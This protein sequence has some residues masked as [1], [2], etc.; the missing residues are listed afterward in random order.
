MLSQLL[1]QRTGNTEGFRPGLTFPLFH[2]S[3]HSFWFSVFINL[4][5]PMILSFTLPQ[6]LFPSG[7]PLT[8]SLPTQSPKRFHYKLVFT[9]HHSYLVSSLFSHTTIQLFEAP[10]F[11]DPLSLSLNSTTFPLSLKPPQLHFHLCPAKIPPSILYTLT[12]NPG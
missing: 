7:K 8:L 11:S 2:N 9:N 1:Q 6:P 12:Y 5:P 10:H 4:S 3:C